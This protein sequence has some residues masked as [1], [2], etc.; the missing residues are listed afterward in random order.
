MTDLQIAFIGLGNRGGPMAA[1]LVKAG[2]RLIDYDVYDAAKKGAGQARM[3]TAKSATDAVAKA[4][5]IFTMLPDARY[6]MDAW[7]DILPATPELAV[8]VDAP[9]SGEAVDAQEATLTFMLGG[10]DKAFDIVEPYLVHM[11]KRS[12]RCG[13]AGSGQAARICNNMILGISIVG[14]SEAFVLAENLGLPHQAFFDVAS[15]SSGQRWSLT[16]YC[17]VPGLVPTSPSSSGYKPG[18][19]ATTLLKDLRPG[20]STPPTSRPRRRHRERLRARYPIPL[21]PTAMRTRIFPPSSNI[22]AICRAA[23]KRRAERIIGCAAVSGFGT[24][25]NDTVKIG[26]NA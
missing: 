25:G 19:A 16:T 5:L 4:S 2:C 26:A 1:N 18:T 12:V 10:A 24:G 15:T 13:A 14:V 11:G 3:E 22:S 6:V 8:I 21:P 20:R 9:V 23:R 17:P 7:K